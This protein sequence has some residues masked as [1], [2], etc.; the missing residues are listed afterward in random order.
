MIRLFWLFFYSSFLSSLKSLP[1]FQISTQRTGMRKIPRA[2]G[3]PILAERKGKV[4]EIDI[5]GVCKRLFLCSGVLVVK[6]YKPEH[7]NT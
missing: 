7:K 3:S 6:S 1:K 2:R 5:W 4:T